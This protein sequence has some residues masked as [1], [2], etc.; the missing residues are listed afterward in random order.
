MLCYRDMT[1]CASDACTNTE[2][3]RHKKGPLY[4]PPDQFW[5]DHTAWSNFH[6]Y[7]CPDYKGP[8]EKSKKKEDQ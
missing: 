2:C 3:V 7:G 4:N 6:A 1:F 5:K 8:G